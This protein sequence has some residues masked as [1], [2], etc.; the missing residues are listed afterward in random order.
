MTG[1]A[2]P[3]SPEARARARLTVSSI[4]AFDVDVIAVLVFATVGRRTH[5]HGLDIAGILGTAWPFLVGMVLGWIVSR[6]WKR[7]LAP[8]STGLVVWAFAWGLGMAL[9]AGTG[10]G[11]APAFMLVALGFLGLTLVGWRVVATLVVGGRAA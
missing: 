2:A 7:P 6:A 9:R 4:M 10:G 8:W 5:E 1:P 3:V 11:T